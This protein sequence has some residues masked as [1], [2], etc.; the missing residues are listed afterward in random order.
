MT[1]PVSTGIGLA[2]AVQPAKGSAITTDSEFKRMRVLSA[3][4]GNQQ[5]MGNFPI[6]VGGGYHPGGSYKI[7]NVGAGRVSMYPRIEGDIG[8]LIYMLMGGVQTAA[9][10]TS[11]GV[12][13]TTFTPR[14]DIY[15]HPWLTARRYI[16]NS[17]G[18]AQNEGEIMTDAKVASGIFSI[19]AAAPAGLEL[20]LLSIGSSWSS[21]AS[22]WPDDMDSAYEDTSSII[23]APASAKP[24]LKA[25]AGIDM[26]DGVNTDF[27]V[28]TISMRMMITNTFSGSNIVNELVVGEYQM[29][30]MVLLS[31]TIA[32]DMVYKW[33]D[34]KLA[35][36][37]YRHGH[38]AY[39]W[40]PTVMSTELELTLRSPTLV[41]S[42]ATQYQE[43]TFNLASCD[44]QCP[45]GI[46]QV[47][48]GY[49]TMR[50]SGVATIQSTAEAYATIKL[51][52][53]TPYTDLPEYVEYT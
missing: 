41:G 42:S 12:Y 25:V 24:I 4:V 6:E 17:A 9:D 33:K 28:P 21:D 51:I 14:T 43:M 5:A 18:G 11:E 19:G 46:T 8:Y 36:D 38:N 45:G 13:T 3:N 40:S 32:F 44:L 15:T 31:Q 23:L 22:S 52:N 26:G 7:Y 20:A 1:E 30:D 27:E 39:S 48:G 53:G 29:D 49:L 47:A 2:F 34:P 10:S 16:P 35:R 50:V 37:I